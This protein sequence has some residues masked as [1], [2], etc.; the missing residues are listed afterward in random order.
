MASQPESQTTTIPV[1]INIS[2]RKSNPIMKFDPLIEYNMRNISLEKS[3]TKWGGETIPIPR[4]QKRK[5]K[6]LFAS[7]V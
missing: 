6:H 5:V 2:R 3:N 7:I 1:L 4:P